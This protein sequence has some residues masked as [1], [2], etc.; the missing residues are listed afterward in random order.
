M[1]ASGCL[2]PCLGLDSIVWEQ[3]YY[4]EQILVCA[5]R[6]AVGFCRAGGVVDCWLRG[7]VG[8][9]GEGIQFV[10]VHVVGGR[11]SGVSG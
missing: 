7:G 9:C 10:G 4:P 5:E 2:R 1:F 3:S 6:R 11:D 8:A